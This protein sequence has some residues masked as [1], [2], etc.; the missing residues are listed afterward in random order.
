MS[1]IK[2]TFCLLP[3]SFFYPFHSVFRPSSSS[4]SPVQISTVQKLL[5]ERSPQQWL[6]NSVP[7]SRLK[8]L[9]PHWENPS[10]ILILETWWGTLLWI[11]R[12]MWGQN[13]NDNNSD[14][15]TKI[16]A[17]FWHL[18]H[19][20]TISGIHY[21]YSHF[22]DRPWSS[23][24]LICLEKQELFREGTRVLHPG[25]SH[26]PCLVLTHCFIG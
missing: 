7:R 19:T 1:Y 26:S 20:T 13:N 11:E 6:K 22:R 4:S 10:P 3:V 8:L 23:E 5:T 16:I 2:Y 18:L 14:D 21:F 24:R 9:V 15:D 12:S 17:S 25:L